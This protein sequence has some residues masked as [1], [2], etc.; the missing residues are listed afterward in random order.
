MATARKTLTDRT[1]KALK[2]RPDKKP[3]EKPDGIVPSL[4]IRVTGTGHKSFVLIKR[5]PGGR[6]PTRR[7]LGAYGALTLEKGRAKGR[8][9]L[10][11]ISRGEDPAYASSRRHDSTFAA[12]LDDYINL[13]VVGPD[14]SNPKQ[15]RG[16]EVAR[17][18]RRVFVP[19]WHAR[20]ITGITRQDV[21][22]AI[23]TVRDHGT[24]KLIRRG[25]GKGSRRPAP[26][27]ARNLLAALKTFFSWAIERGTYGLTSSPCDHLRARRIIGEKTSRDRILSDAELFALWRTAKR[28]RY[29]YGPVY[30]LLVLTALR[31]NECAG[32]R[33]VEFD[34]ANKLWTVPASRMKGTNGRARP[35]AVPLTPAMLALLDTLP[36][37]GEFVF[38]TTFG[39]TP[40][41]IGDK[42][43]RTLDARMLRTLRAL[44]RRRG[45]DARKVTLQ[46]WR[47]H[48]LRRVVRSALSRLRVNPEV[49]EALLAHVQPGIKGTYNLYDFID[50]RRSALEVWG[51]YLQQIT[52]PPT[53][54]RRVVPLRPVGA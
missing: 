47:N 26:T 54:S 20:P 25:K 36:R 39:Q 29:P 35:H 23:E 10:E 7:S 38:S 12:V 2:P 27:L 33:W 19:L 43:K 16:N 28:L 22:R 1:I 41:W 37:C 45:E 3:Y 40:T 44:A 18:L 21:L 42:I 24:G 6:D 51:N 49:A 14:P 30:Q 52:A 31:L 48:D 34:L 9:W 46:P 8:D 5:F 32:A 11:A 15:R 17:D 4:W 13:V 50:E 53:P